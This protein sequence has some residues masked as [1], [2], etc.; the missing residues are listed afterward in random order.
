MLKFLLVYLLP[1][2]LAAGFFHWLSKR[3]RKPTRTSWV[4]CPRCRHDMNG[5][6]ESFI[7]DVEGI[8]LYRCAG[9]GHEST[10]DFAHYPVPVCVRGEVEENKND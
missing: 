1:T 4:W 6:N 2:L 8:V 9:C 3:D 10:F 5:D 7:Q